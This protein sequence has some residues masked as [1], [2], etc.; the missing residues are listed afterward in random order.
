MALRERDRKIIGLLA[1]LRYGEV[2]ARLMV[3]E[4]VREEGVDGE[5]KLQVGILWEVVQHDLRFKMT[6]N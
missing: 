3:Q 5:G 1:T 6:L 4:D 2:K